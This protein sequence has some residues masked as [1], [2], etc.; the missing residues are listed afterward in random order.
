[1][2]LDFRVL[3]NGG[4]LEKIW[5]CKRGVTTGSLG[6]VLDF[7]QEEAANLVLANESISQD[8]I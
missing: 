2:M 7:G 5:L 3:I 4:S 1:M 8:Q 6:E